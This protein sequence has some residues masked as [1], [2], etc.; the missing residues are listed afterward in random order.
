[1]PIMRQ[2]AVVLACACAVKTGCGFGTTSLL[3]GAVAS[4]SFAVAA[5]LYRLPGRL[6]DVVHLDRT[7]F[8]FY[9]LL[10]ARAIT[11]VIAGNISIAWLPAAYVLAGSLITILGLK[12]NDGVIRGTG[13]V[14][15]YWFAQHSFISTLQ[16]TSRFGSAIIFGLFLYLSHLFKKVESDDRFASEHIMQFVHYGAAVCVLTH[17]IGQIAPSLWMSPAW[18]LEGILFLLYGF[19]RQDKRA[20]IAALCV[21]TL[22]AEILVSLDLMNERYMYLLDFH[23]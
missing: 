10:T 16:D 22:A 2:F 18:G 1:M 3:M 14:V 20:R 11:S 8:Y 13:V 7:A 19:F 9:F 4:L 21:L 15:I 6:G 17:L 23:S 12:L 5:L